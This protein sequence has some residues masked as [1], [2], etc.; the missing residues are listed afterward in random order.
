MKLLAL[1]FVN[2]LTYQIMQGTIREKDPVPDPQDNKPL[3]SFGL[4]ADVQYCECKAAGTR[5]YSS[6]LTKL[7][8]AFTTFKENS[9]PFIINLGDLIEKDFK[10]FKPLTEIIDS[11]GIK[12]Y[13][14]TGNHDYSVEPGMKKRIPIFDNNIKGYYSFTRKGFR[15]IILNG[16]EIS[17]YSSNNSSIIRQA[18]KLLADL[19]T[20]N[21][22]N[23][24]EWNGGIGKRQIEWLDR[25]LE[26]AS[27]NNERVFIFCHFPVWPENVHNLLNYNDILPVLKNYNNIIAWFNGHNHMGNYAN[28][29]LIH[30]V[31]LKGMVETP[32]SNSFMIVEV[33]SNKIWIKGFGREKS[34]ILAY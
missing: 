29:N 30:F 21:E 6:S 17:I 23:A 7:R 32:D 12:V 3:F 16:N 34:R 31:T 22:V 2:L 13:H 4:I 27:E 1:L 18:D 20:G 5:Y 10:S 26:K 24:M 14:C 25:Q 9:V 19:K 28:L 33:Y 15:F 8:E 11:S